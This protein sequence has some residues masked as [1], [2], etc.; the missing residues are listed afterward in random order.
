VDNLFP[1]QALLCFLPALINIGIAVYVFLFL[2]RSKTVEVFGFFVIALTCW[3]V[4]DGLF[5]TVPTHADADYVDRFFAFSWCAAGPLALH[6]AGNYAGLPFFRRR[7]VL[8]GIYLPFITLHCFYI[9]SGHS[10][11][12]HDAFWGWVVTP[13]AVWMDIV[14]MWMEAT[15]MLLVV[16]ILLTHAWRLRRNPARR[17]AATLVGIGILLPTIAG[18]T[19]QL[20]FPVIFKRNEI[21]LTS[22]FM[23]FFSLAT[24]IA[25]SRYELFD[26]RHALTLD[27]V[28]QQVRNIV[29]VVSP[30]KDMRYLNAYSADLFE[31]G[32]PSSRQQLRILFSDD[33]AYQQFLTG[34]LEPA[35]DGKPARNRTVAFQTKDGK[36]M[37]ALV[38][39]QPVW[40]RR[41][42]QGVLVVAN[43]ITDHLQLLE[44]LKESNGRFHAEQM[45][46]HRVITEAVLAAQE[47][48]RRLIG[49]E[50][51]DNVNQILTSAQL[52]L[53]LTLTK[54]DNERERFG[55]TTNDIISKAMQEVRKLSHTLIPPSLSG[56]TLAE[57]LQHLL[58]SSQQSGAF[59]V[60]L[61]LAGFH[62]S[63]VSNKLKLTIYRIVQEQWSNVIKHAC[64]QNVSVTL[65][66]KRNHL[67]L[68]ISDDG[69]G[70]DSDIHVRGVGLKNIETRALLHEGIVTLAT[71]P[72]K[73]CTLHVEFPVTISA[74]AE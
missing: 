61:D 13:D 49:A 72:G 40:D 32:H 64:A 6:F 15:A 47:N 53:G 28:L 69:I 65:K 57:A 37:D 22:E 31:T 29:L 52:Y 51:H 10:V 12:E 8:I 70:F 60:Q 43:D 62:E 18:I 41:K 74:F 46:R 7:L 20:L 33:A 21:P 4:A 25:L 67:E 58:Q 55:Q 1:P 5:L 23:T 34:I 16:C 30:Q 11:L 73:G 24:I 45:R 17:V 2:P 56:E 9:A 71:A 59:E 44:E 48:E 38:V 39:A 63:L 50:L 54:D 27:A 26:I 42:I 3:Q 36:R 19:S 68:S 35:F 66:H 14:L